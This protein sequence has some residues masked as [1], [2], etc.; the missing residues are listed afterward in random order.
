MKR[1]ADGDTG[2]RIPATQAHDEIGEMARTV[3]VFRDT[4][5]ERQNSPPLRPRASRAKDGAH[6]YY[7]LPPSRNSSTRSKARSAS[8]ARRR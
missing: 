2:A 6:L 8:C 1:L 3:I 7:R 4:M 5:V